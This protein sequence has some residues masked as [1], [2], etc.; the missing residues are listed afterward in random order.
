MLSTLVRNWWVFVV[1]GLLAILFG[2]LTFIMP[3]LSLLSLIILFGA[4]AI[5]AG[6]MTLISVARRTDVEGR[7]LWALILEGIVSIAAGVIAFI[8]PGLTALAL[9][10][11]I[12]AWFFVTG[13]LEIAVAVRLRAYITGEWLLAL[14]GALSVLFGS[15]LFLF[16]G[17]GAL[18]MVFWIGACAIAFGALLVAFGLRLRRAM[19]S[20]APASHHSG[21]FASSH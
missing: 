13:I 6:V 16:P 3:G 10:Y 9:L 15:L 18:A 11:L 2:I 20:S 4:Y 17:A 19:P 14:T 12:A 8:L 1:R 21:R 5:A 7:P